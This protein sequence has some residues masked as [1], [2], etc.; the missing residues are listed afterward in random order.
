MNNYT[1]FLCKQSPHGLPSKCPTNLAKLVPYLTT[2]GEPYT[3][4]R[5]LQA[6]CSVGSVWLGQIDLSHR[7]SVF[8]TG[9]DSED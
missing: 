2:T 3:S 1:G 9:S 5:E 8:Q 4:S 6:D 7:C